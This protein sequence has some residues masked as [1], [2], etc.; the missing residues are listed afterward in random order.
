METL[1]NV[2]YQLSV[3][4][5]FYLFRCSHEVDGGVVAVIFLKQA[6]CKL[7]I[8]QQVV[9]K[10]QR[11]KET[12]KKT[13][14]T[15]TNLLKLSDSFV[16]RGT[17][18]S[19]VLQPVKLSLWCH[20]ST[21]F[22]GV[23]GALI[24]SILPLIIPLRIKPPFPTDFI[25]DAVEHRQIYESKNAAGNGASVDIQLDESGYSGGVLDGDLNQWQNK[26][27]EHVCAY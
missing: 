21:T 10:R 6:E 27:G 2:N 23:F 18:L 22:F 12:W 4:H 9:L 19:F 24:T 11:Q 20:V 26:Q 25:D 17:R 16:S 7:V 1:L 3:C 14:R 5:F 13:T 8:D 15:K